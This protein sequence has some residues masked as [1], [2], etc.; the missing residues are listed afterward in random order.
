[1]TDG[2][3][4]ARAWE[5]AGRPVVPSLVV[6]GAA[7]PILHRSQLASLLGLPPAAEGE[8]TA[9]A[10]DCVG[11]LAAWVAAIGPLPFDVLLQPTP[12]RG[13]S[14]RNLTVNVCHPFELLPTACTRGGFD[15]D[16]ERDG[17]REAALADARSVVAYAAERHRGWLAFLGEDGDRLD[18]GLEVRTPR[19]ALTLG[20]LLAQ[21]RWHAAYHYRQLTAFLAAVGRPPAGRFPLE[22]LPGLDLPAEVF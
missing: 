5:A 7:T 14:L 18:P 20:G 16:P 13:R 3:E 9:L 1:M 22:R 4:G 12:S 17:E 15:W 11:L 21:Q 10:W 2:G 8:A 6:A 19:G